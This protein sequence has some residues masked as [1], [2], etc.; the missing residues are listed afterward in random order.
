MREWIHHRCV[1]D[2]LRVQA[3]VVEWI[4]LHNDAEPT[5]R[6]IGVAVLDDP[7]QL[8]RTATVE[9]LPALAVKPAIVGTPKTRLEVVAVQVPV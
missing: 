1:V 8:V 9:R 4:A 5:K 6:P 3:R 2:A 7:C